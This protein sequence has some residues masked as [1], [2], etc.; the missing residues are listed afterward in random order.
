MPHQ[1]GWLLEAVGNGSP[2]SE[3]LKHF[4]MDFEI[5]ELE[6]MFENSHKDKGILIGETN[7]ELQ[8]I[9]GQAIL[10]NSS[11]SKLSSAIQNTLNNP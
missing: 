9:A 8:R 11:L 7:K 4:P 6:T 5:Q 1:C 3:C 2:A 10:V